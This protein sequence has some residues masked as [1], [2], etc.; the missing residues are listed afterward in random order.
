[1]SKESSSVFEK[2]K[3]RALAKPETA[4]EYRARMDKLEKDPEAR[5]SLLAPQ[6]GRILRAARQKRRLTQAEQAEASGIL[7]SEI[8][9]IETGGGTLG[10]SMETM[11]NYAHALDMEVVLMLKPRESALPADLVRMFG[12][13]E[14]KDGGAADEGAVRLWGIF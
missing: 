10:P 9:R 11:V 13:A 12:E 2:F 5:L 1:M 3:A 8:S 7:Q 6:V 4:R 14:A